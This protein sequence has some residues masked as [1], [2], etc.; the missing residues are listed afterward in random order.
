M[1]GMVLTFGDGVFMAGKGGKPPLNFS[2]SNDY[3]THGLMMSFMILIIVY[4]R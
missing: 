4:H 1:D 2:W 3:C